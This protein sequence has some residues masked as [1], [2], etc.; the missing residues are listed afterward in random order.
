MRI[1]DYPTNLLAGFEHVTE[2]AARFDRYLV[3]LRAASDLAE[4]MTEPGTV[5][6]LGEV[7]EAAQVYSWKL[8]KHLEPV[9]HPP[10]APEHQEPV[11]VF[12]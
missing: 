12:P 10:P 1:P 11:D 7:I 4:R 3:G 9:D 5:N 6:L 2:V 8:V